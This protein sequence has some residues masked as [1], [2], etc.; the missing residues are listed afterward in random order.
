MVAV[1]RTG[2]QASILKR[3]AGGWASTLY[4]D[5][6]PTAK[7]YSAALAPDGRIW[8]AFASG[9][10]AYNPMTDAVTTVSYAPAPQGLSV[11]DGQIW[12][13]RDTRTTI[14]RVSVTGSTQQTINLPAENAIYG[15]WLEAAR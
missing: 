1:A 11:V 7:G 9:I 2:G 10:R 15:H 8:M 14:D 12:I 4:K 6:V 3:T 5:G 13:I